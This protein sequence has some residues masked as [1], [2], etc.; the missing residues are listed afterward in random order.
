MEERLNIRKTLYEHTTG[1]KASYLELRQSFVEEQQELNVQKHRY[2][3]S[4]A[5]LAT[6]AE[7][8]VQAIEEYRRTRLSDL[9]EAERKARGLYEDLLKAQHRTALQILTAPV[10]GT[11]QQLAVHTVGGVVTPAQTLLVLVP[12]DSQL[13]IQAMVLNRDIGFVYAGQ[14][15][16]VK[17]DAFNFNRYGLIHGKVISLSPDAITREKL[18][19]KHESTRQTPEEDTSEPNDQELVYA[20]RISLERSQMQVED[21][22]VDLAPGMAV[23]VEIKTG[24]RRI[25]SYLLSPLLRYKQET[26]RER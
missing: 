3:E 26:L 25:I 7:Q 5:A 8:Q 22:L 10:D 9:A 19:G 13:E 2:Q 12:L 17:V 11:V 20:A 21:K 23:T 4:S 14:E 1:S 24:S 15:A 18:S 6:I 16:E